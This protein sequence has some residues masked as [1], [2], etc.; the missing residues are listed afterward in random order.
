MML[1]ETR[2]QWNDSVETIWENDSTLHVEANMMRLSLTDLTPGAHEAFSQLNRG[3]SQAQLN[4][5]VAG[6]D[7]MKGMFAFMPRFSRLLASGMIAHYLLIED[8]LLAS[9]HPLSNTY[10]FH[11][12]EI[13]PDA[14]YI[15]SRFASLRRDI[16]GRLVL[17]CPLGSAAIRITEDRSCRILWALAQPLSI[18]SIVERLNLPDDVVTM[19]FRFLLTAGALSTVTDENIAEDENAV[20]RQWEA[21]DLLF[22]S[23]VRMGR[24]HEL[25]GMNYR[26]L[27]AIPQQPITK[28]IDSP[29]E[30]I[31]L[32]KPDVNTL[33]GAERTFTDVLESRK[34]R[35]RHAADQA[36]T[37]DQIGEFLYRCARMRYHFSFEVEANGTVETVH[38]SN[39]PYPNAGASYELELYLSVSN[40]TGL[41]PGF[42]HYDP[43]EH[44][45]ARISDLNNAV[46][47]LLWQA[48]RSWMAEHDGSSPQ[49]LITYGARFQ[50]VNWKYE[51]IA[52]ALTL[53][54]VGVLMQTMSLVAEAMGLAGCPIGGGNADVFTRAL[55][56][57]YY[58]E[59]SVGEFILG[60]RPDESSE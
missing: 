40:C 51:S 52:Y 25:Y 14:N 6:K 41:E 20:L 16:Q 46:Q 34:S 44:Q 37:H 39:R 30:V 12:D 15:L 55:G 42:Y 8:V 59:S 22:H 7:G 24:G 26:F 33:K 2:L 23:K 5:I 50:R 43:V 18:N 29:E 57:D 21:H 58:T 38:H 10:R 56:S 9:I 17:E 28:Q 13:D 47:S 31:P 3:V 54:N 36:I 32:Y 27:G 1:V 11:N 49:I 53:K 48:Q 35:P 4:K 19:F 45:L 60:A